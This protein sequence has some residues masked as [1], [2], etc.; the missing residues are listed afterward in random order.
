MT[1][2]LASALLPLVRAVDAERAHGLALAALRL[3]LAGRDTGPDEPRLEMHVLGRRFANP[4]GLAA[5]FDKDARA[6]APLSRLGFGFVETGTV[7]PLPQR[8]NARPR[9]FRLDE[10]R[11]VINRMGFNNAGLDAFLRRSRFGRAAARPGVPVGAN[12][13]INKD[14][15]R[16][17]ARLSR[18]GRGRRAP[19]RLRGDQ[20]LLP[21]HAGAA[22]PTK[23]GRAAGHPGGGARTCAAAGRRCW[24]RSPPICR[25]T[26]IAAVVEACVTHSVA[27]LIVGNTTVTR[28][29]GLR[30]P[31]A[32]RSRAACPA[33]RCSRLSTA[34]WRAP[35]G[36]RRGRLMLI[37][38]GGVSTGAD[39][40]TQIARRALAGAALHRAWSIE[41]PA[42]IRGCR[43]E[44]LAAALNAAGFA[45]AQT[46]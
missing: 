31:H 43:R 12:V 34:C 26:G 11:A 38:A 23:R 22:R 36:W 16:P 41:G 46:R 6:V 44:L 4:I 18:T 42:L 20:R 13:G 33:R 27:G 5:G 39:V 1:P 19:C 10:D 17:G 9:L 29:A 28:P 25:M 14:R 15:R 2:A 35:S 37:G 24:S 32:Q 3:G 30:S 40:L 45:H 8:G 21:E 7:T